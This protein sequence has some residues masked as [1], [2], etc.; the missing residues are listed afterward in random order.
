MESDAMDLIGERFGSLVVKEQCH[1]HTAAWWCECDCGGRTVVA[2]AALERGDITSCPACRATPEEEQLAPSTVVSKPVN[3]K[4]EVGE[5][6]GRLTI[7]AWAGKYERM[8]ECE[9]GTRFKTEI[10]WIRQGTVTEC[11]KCR[12]ISNAIQHL[13]FS[14][15]S[16][17][18]KRNYPFELTY[19]EFVSLVQQDCYYCGTPPKQRHNARVHSNYW[20]VHYNGVDRVDNTKGYVTGNTVPCCGT[21][22]RAKGKMSVEE[23]LDWAAR[24]ASY[25]QINKT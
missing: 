11:P 10:V 18:V 13:Y 19:D 5:K 24:L 14:Y 15:K 23:F 9:C 7:V 1:P 12:N 3:G 25:Q 17:A 16:S 22:N 2:G 4:F 8:C 20:P 21:C 6:Y